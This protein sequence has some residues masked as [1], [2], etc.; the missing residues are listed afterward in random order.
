MPKYSTRSRNALDTA[1]KDLRHVFNYVIRYFDHT[2]IEGHRNEE[3]Q[4]KAFEEGK[5]KLRYPKSKHN[6]YPS[7]AVD[8]VPYP[9]DWNDVNRM[10]FFAG[11]V[12]AVGR[13]MYD[14]G[15][16]EHLVRTG[17][18]WDSD[19]ELKDTRFQDGPHFELY[20]P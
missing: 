1:H 5:S 9:I 17:F 10:R 16:T 13:M 18:D 12:V 4:N 19:T 8:A 6:S 11:F 20:K 14:M 3:K 2:V 7:M 15:A